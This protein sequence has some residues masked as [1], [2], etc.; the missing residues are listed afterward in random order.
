MKTR[1][2]ACGLLAL[3]AACGEDGITG[4]TEITSEEMTVGTG[5]TAAVGDVVTV[6]YVLTLNGTRLESS[7]GGT[8]LTFQ[9]GAGQLIPG[10]ERGVLGMRVGGKRRVTV[11]PALGYGNQPRQGIPANSTLVFEIE[12]VSILGR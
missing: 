5:A 8:P 12:L 6:H 7:Y 3:L 11:P 2:L 10:F 4:P 1:L 9:L